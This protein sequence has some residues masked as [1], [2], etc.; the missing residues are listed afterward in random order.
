M[1]EGGGAEPISGGADGVL[2][3]VALTRRFTR[4]KRAR[5]QWVCWPAG[6]KSTPILRPFRFVLVQQQADGW[7]RVECLT[8][9]VL[10]LGKHYSAN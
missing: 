5:T 10:P 9:F 4:L 6:R 7:G 3:P 1:V 2:L 8:R